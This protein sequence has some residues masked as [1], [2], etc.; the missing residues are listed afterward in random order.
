VTDPSGREWE[1]YAYRFRLSDRGA[2]FDPGMAP[3]DIVGVWPATAAYAEGEEILGLLDAV[4]WALGLIPR[5]LIRLL[6]D[7]PRAALRVPGSDRWTIEAVSWYPH[8]TSRM[9][10]TRGVSRDEALAQIADSIRRGV[11]PHPAD[12]VAERYAEF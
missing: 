1:L 11:I 4:L 3:D 10:I 5:L 2:T 9:W 6:W 12:A 7:I 8:R